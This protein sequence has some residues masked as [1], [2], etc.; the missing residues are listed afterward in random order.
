MNTIGFLGVP[1][2]GDEAQRLFDDDVSGIG[3]VMNTSRLWAYQPATL[4]GLVGLLEETSSVHGLDLRQRAVLITACA[5]ALGDSYC[6]LA[7]G[8]KLADASDAP[9]ASGVLRGDDDRL[10]AGERVLADW[11]RKVARDPNGT[12]GADVQAL[13]DAGFGDAQIFAI[14]VFVALRIAFS[15]VNDA[16]GVGPDAAFR[17]TAPSLLVDAITYGRPI[18]EK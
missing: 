3:Y 18:D 1:E 12:S 5:S 14:T 13:R 15:T 11:A 4:N 16:L 6:S 9:T 7:W 10:T 2:P 17:A 8:G